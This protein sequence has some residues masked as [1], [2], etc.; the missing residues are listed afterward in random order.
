MT[1]RRV[2][3]DGKGESSVTEEWG[4]GV[5]RCNWRKKGIGV[6]GEWRGQV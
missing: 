2:R 6:T 1:R 4:K 3:Y 5:V